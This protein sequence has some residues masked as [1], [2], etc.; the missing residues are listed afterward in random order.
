M[1]IRYPIF[2]L[3]VSLLSS[4]FVL[5]SD[6]SSK[7]LL[8]LLQAQFDAYNQR[9]IERMVN[10]VSGDFK[11]YSLTADK[12]LV[13]TSG[14]ISFKKSMQD[15]YQSRPQ[16]IHSIIESYTIDGNRISFKEVVSHQNKEG[17]KVSSS[18]MGIYEF[19]EGKIYRAWY[20]AD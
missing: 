9:D 10:N 4:P 15:Y 20:F 3:I 13:E 2:L 12:L 5:S 17:K 8:K 18:A 7:P 14:K 16:K 11:W 1:N 6:H 19:K